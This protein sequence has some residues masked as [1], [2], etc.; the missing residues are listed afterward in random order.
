MPRRSDDLRKNVSHEDGAVFADDLS[1]SAQIQNSSPILGENRGLG[2]AASGASDPGAYARE[3]DRS[4]RREKGPQRSEAGVDP[5]L[6]VDGQ[7]G[8]AIDQAV[9]RNAV[10]LQP[11]SARFLPASGCGIQNRRHWKRGNARL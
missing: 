9:S 5:P 10:R 2:V 4:A 7:A 8:F 1:R 3:T 11:G 6:K